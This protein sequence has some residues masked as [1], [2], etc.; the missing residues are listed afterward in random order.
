MGVD[1][2][3]AS[4]HPSTNALDDIDDPELDEDGLSIDRYLA[5]GTTPRA[6]HNPPKPGEVVTYKVKVE[7]TGESWKVRSDGEIRYSADLNILSV[8][9]IDEEL[10]PDFKSKKQEQE[11]AKAA[12]KK[13][14]KGK[15]LYDNPNEPTLPM[16]GDGKSDAEIDAEIAAQEKAEDKAEGWDDGYP[17]P[18]GG[19]E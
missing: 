13:A 2:T 8:A 16:D 5:F 9:R 14:A 11:E 18:H 6:I 10:P 17:E 1:T 4:D 15:G 3:T 19:D 12:A 7:T